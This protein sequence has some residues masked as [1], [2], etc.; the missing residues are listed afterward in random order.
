VSQIVTRPGDRGRIRAAVDHSLAL[1]GIEHLRERQV[2]LLTTGERRLVELAR[3]LAGP[4]DVVLLDEPSSGLDASETEQFGAV[5]AHVVAEQGIGLLLVEHDMALVME[6]CQHI[7]VVDFGQLIF[8]GAPDEVRASETVQ[9]AYL[10]TE[11]TAHEAAPVG[12][13]AYVGPGREGDG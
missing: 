2:A 8:E 6:V 5:L 11:A 9:A 3:S 7:Y 10:G 1:T 13:P 12:D 4:F